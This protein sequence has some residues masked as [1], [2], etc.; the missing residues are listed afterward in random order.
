MYPKS[1][2]KYCSF[3]AAIAIIAILTGSCTIGLEPASFNRKTSLTIRIAP[4][5][6]A[7]RDGEDRAGRSGRADRA[8]ATRSG[9]LYIQTGIDPATAAVYGPY[10]AGPES[11]VTITDI[12]AGTYT[13]L[14]LAYVPT[15]LD[16]APAPVYPNGLSPESARLAIQES[17]TDED[18]RQSS[19]CAFV[20]RFELLEGK[21]NEVSATFVPTTDLSYGSETMPLRGDPSKV[22]RRFIRI[23]NVKKAYS[24]V[25]ASDP[26]KMKFM[27]FAPKD[28]SASLTSFALYS[29]SGV[30]V[31][32][33][34][35]S[36]TITSDSP[37]T[38]DVEWSGDDSY[39]AFVEY[40]ADALG[41]FVRFAEPPDTPDTP[42]EPIPG[43]DTTSPSA[44]ALRICDLNLGESSRFILTNSQSVK[45]LLNYTETGSGISVISISGASSLSDV[46]VTCDGTARTVHTVEGS[47]ITLAT[48]VVGEGKT[49]EI[50]GVTLPT[51]DG[52][53]SVSVTLTDASGNVGAVGPASTTLD[54]APPTI[55]ITL[56]ENMDAVDPILVGKTIYVR[57][58][59]S[60]T[61]SITDSSGIDGTPIITGADSVSG[62][63]VFGPVNGGALSFR[64][65]DK[66]GNLLQ[67]DITV[68]MDPTGPTV[69]E[70]STDATSVSFTAGFTGSPCAKY[71]VYQTSTIE[72]GS[73]TALG[74]LSFS[75]TA[76]IENET[77]VAGGKSASG[78]FSLTAAGYHYI[79]LLMYDRI[80]NVSTYVIERY[81][82]GSSYSC[83]LPAAL[84]P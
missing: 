16:I 12:P 49:M 71:S 63:T 48:P 30:R 21:K 82:N 43:P 7:T 78:L 36:H 66:A 37:Y 51:G 35:T 39:Y 74:S 79:K 24:G 10:E 55:A 58:G 65:Y 46:S 17:L 54:T 84:N 42:A 38:A 11:T 60:L 50:T 44:E 20:E 6:S 64:A 19:S 67:L 72:T 68:N 5:A 4:P 61:Y 26:K 32:G 33:D 53:K 22:S 29:A 83:T 41:F 69:S 18:L 76:V 62:S 9:F 56:G 31:H 23:D 27:L 52:S 45:L 57:A 77:C 13:P 75:S 70:L 59:G 81:Y 8:L 34:A 3:F 80:G 73:V 1:C 25:G 40:A 28:A 47:T 2:K 15:R 14:L